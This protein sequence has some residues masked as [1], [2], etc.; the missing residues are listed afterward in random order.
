MG[1]RGPLGK[2][3][4]RQARWGRDKSPVRLIVAQPV[5]QPELPEFDCQVKID[6]VF[7]T[8][9]FYWPP[10]TRRWWQM[11]AD[12]PLSAEFTESDWEYLLD[13]ALLHARFWNGEVKLA[14]ELRLRVAK[15][16]ATPEDRARLKIQFADSDDAQERR[17]RKKELSASRKRRGP[18][19]EAG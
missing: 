2:D 16:G 4:A 17:E 1:S 3:P 7:V 18:L 9:E 5:R 14:A 10:A 15:F 13:T 12:N 11:W 6:G 19:T 8:Q